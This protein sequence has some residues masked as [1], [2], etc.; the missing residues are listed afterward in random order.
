MCRY[1]RNSYN[2]LHCTTHIEYTIQKITFHDSVSF[3]NYMVSYIAE[4]SKFKYRRILD[5]RYESIDRPFSDSL[6]NLLK[7]NKRLFHS[8]LHITGTYT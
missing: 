5:I 1:I 3:Q 2:K 7:I 4:G 8:T 6:I